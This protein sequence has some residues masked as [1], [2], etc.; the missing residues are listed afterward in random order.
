MRIRTSFVSSIAALIASVA[1]LSGC[2]TDHPEAK[3]QSAGV[4]PPASYTPAP[5]PSEPAE[6]IS[7]IE[8]Q[9]FEY[10]RSPER[11]ALL[12]AALAEVGSDWRARMLAGEIP[13]HTQRD[14]LDKS[15]PSNGYAE[16]A[17]NNEKGGVKPGETFIQIGIQMRDGQVDLDQPP[18]FLFIITA[19]RRMLSLHGDSSYEPDTDRTNSWDSASLGSPDSFRGFS[20]LDADNE[21]AG[22]L[23]AGEEYKVKGYWYPSGHTVTIDD[24]KTADDEFLGE[25]RSLNVNGSLWR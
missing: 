20:L 12:N 9:A 24:I 8:R 11:A 2:A 4:N 25:L 18:S 23:K 17:S 14:K 19:N 21:V 7:P 5:A 1:V 16:L 10:Y 15:T 3:N 6:K 13:S 22:V